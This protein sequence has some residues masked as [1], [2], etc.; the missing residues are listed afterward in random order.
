MSSSSLASP[1]SNRGVVAAQEDVGNALPAERA[2]ARV[3][4]IFEAAVGPERLVDRALGIT[5]DAGHQPHDGIDDDHGRD[6]A[7]RKY[8]VADRETLGAERVEDPLVEPL[9][10]AADQDQPRLPRQLP[11]PVLVE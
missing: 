5:Q 9:I 1:A 3:L 10:T 8:I 6:L 2:R 7:P 4:G 11:D